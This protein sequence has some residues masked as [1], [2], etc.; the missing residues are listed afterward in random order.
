MRAPSTGLPERHQQARWLIGVAFLMMVVTRLPLACGSHS[1]RGHY[2][3]PRDSGRS[4][5]QEEGVV[6][7]KSRCQ[8]VTSF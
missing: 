8:C 1:P 6:R 2:T 3:E 4:D 5:R 7:R